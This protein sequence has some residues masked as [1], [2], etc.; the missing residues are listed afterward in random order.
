[1]QSDIAKRA[2]ATDDRTSRLAIA[3]T[4]LRNLVER[5]EPFSPELATVRSLA[6]DPKSL[7]TLAPFAES[8]VP[9][10]AALSRQLTGLVPMMTRAAVA[11]GPEGGFLVKLQANA[12]QLVRI[13]PVGD[14]AGDDAASILARVE[15]KASLNDIPGALAE[16]GKLPEEVRAPAEDWIKKARARV[17]AIDTAR[18]FAAA[19][20]SALGKS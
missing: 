17:A 13:R 11:S 10:G 2:A 12:Q 14:V 7:S 9:S 19:A 5:G 6:P 16:I 1:M 15:N 20:L 3:A 4:S 8:G 18:Q